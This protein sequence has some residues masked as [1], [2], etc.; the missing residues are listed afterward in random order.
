MPA[1][2]LRLRNLSLEPPN[3]SLRLQ[4]SMSHL[5]PFL[6]FN[7][8]LSLARLL[9]NLLRSFELRDLPHVHVEGCPFGVQ[10]TSKLSPGCR[11]LM[12]FMDS[13]YMWVG[14]C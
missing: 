13:V 6:E 1:G 12:L 10:E 7:Q 11:I 8:M 5:V 3:E 14:F 2:V 4:T 9:R